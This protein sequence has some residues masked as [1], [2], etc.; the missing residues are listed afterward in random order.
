MNSNQSAHL[1]KSEMFNFNVYPQPYKP[2]KNGLYPREFY[3][4]YASSLYNSTNNISRQRELDISAS[5]INFM[6]LGGFG[7]LSCGCGDDEYN[8]GNEEEYVEEYDYKELKETKSKLHKDLI[9]YLWH[10]S[11]LAK[12]LEN[13]DSIDSYLN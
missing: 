12:Y 3:S 2:S 5:A 8:S 4:Q 10:P 1:E 7:G 13:H 9:E 6:L 11:K